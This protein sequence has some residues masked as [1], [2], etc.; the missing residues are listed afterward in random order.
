M[1]L[2]YHDKNPLMNHNEYLLASLLHDIGFFWKAAGGEKSHSELGAEF[3]RKYFP[4]FEPSAEAIENHHMP[5]DE[6]Q[7]KI[8]RADNLSLVENEFEDTKKLINPFSLIDFKGKKPDHMFYPANPLN[9][10][11][12]IFPVSKPPCNYQDLW[13]Q[14]IK[15]IEKV[16]KDNFFVMFNSLIHVLHKYT[17]C[18]PSPSDKD[19]TISLFHHLKTTSAIASC[20]LFDEDEFI[21]I[22]GDISGVQSFIYTI[23]SKGAAKSLKG[24]SFFLDLLND[25]IARYIVYKLELPITNVLFC[26]GGNFLVLAPASMEDKVRNIKD[27]I[28]NILLESFEGNLYVVLDTVKF[29]RSDMENP[30]RMLQKWRDLHQ[31]MGESKKK[32]FSELMTKEQFSLIFG[33]FGEGGFSPFCEVCKNE[34]ADMEEGKCPLCKSFKNLT[35]DV[36]NAK[37]LVEY[38]KETE[39]N[40]TKNGTVEDIFSKFGFTYK[41]VPSL[42]DIESIEVDKAILYR[43]QNTDFLVETPSN[44]AK[45]FLFLPNVIPKQKEG[46]KYSGLSLDELEK[47]SKGLQSLAVLRADVDNLGKIF[48]IGL[49]F[50][51]S[52]LSGLSHLLSLFFQGYLPR[53]IEENYS[54]PE[55]DYPT[56]MYVVYSGGDDCFIIGPWDRIFDLADKI[57]EEFTRYTCSNENITL[58]AGI[59]LVGVK[60]PI[61]K[62]ADMAGKALD[63]SKDNGKNRITI[64]RKDFQWDTEFS[65]VKKLK[66]LVI[67]ALTEKKVSRALLFRISENFSDFERFKEELKNGSI[68]THRI[69]R[70]FYVISR[71]SRN[72]KDATE[73]LNKIREDYIDIIQASTGNSESGPRIKPEIIP[74]AVRWAEFL[75]RGEKNER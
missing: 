34:S 54:N 20:L 25:T 16:P 39:R 19:T 11:E 66:D 67:A 45:G 52:A 38:Y 71:F 7:K 1:F 70:F 33:P 22:G 24:R 10:D 8:Q 56:L 18:V 17:W 51:L 6:F 40:N 43:I 21:L 27:E 30:E 72:Y 46:D 55:K 14:F 4:Q 23:T 44:Y 64:L 48:S 65:R 5:L 42:D 59:S 9:L 60:F 13:E 50:N 63:E 28:I 29:C 47:E 69:W 41:L 35:D 61:Y 58:S 32:R 49:P 2:Y 31:C 53:Y 36:L 15:D 26:G 3:V 75:T 62:G 57:H 12:S 74:V 37:Y 68:A 73:E